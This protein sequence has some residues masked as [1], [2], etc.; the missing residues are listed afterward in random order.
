MLFFGE[1]LPF[2]LQQFWI[3]YGR[4]Y[5]LPQATESDARFWKWVCIR[6]K[7]SLPVCVSIPW[8]LAWWRGK[9]QSFSQKGRCFYNQFIKNHTEGRKKEERNTGKQRRGMGKKRRETWST[10]AWLVMLEFSQLAWLC[11]SLT[12]PP[13]VTQLWETVVVYAV[14]ILS[15]PP[16]PLFLMTFSDHRILAGPCNRQCKSIGKSIP[17]PSYLLLNNKFPYT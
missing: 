7:G 16:D 6:A 3:G 13:D 9:N 2:P 1:L 17:H 5:C 4:P 15:Q 8:G 12:P 10:E 11:P 14:N